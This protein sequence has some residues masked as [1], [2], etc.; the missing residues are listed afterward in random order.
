MEAVEFRCPWCAEVV[1]VPV[2]QLVVCESPASLLMECPV[3]QRS[4]VV[5]VNDEI[6]E[7]LQLLGV[8]V[9]SPLER[10][11]AVHPAGK[12]RSPE[13]APPAAVQ[14]SPVSW[15]DLLDFHELLEEDDWFDQ[16]SSLVA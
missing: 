10:S 6:V 16:L 12:G 2:E 13:L 14:G 4:G 7:T 3:C 11:L 9:A 15:D 1:R 8:S 5:E